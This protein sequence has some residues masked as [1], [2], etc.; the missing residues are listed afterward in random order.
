MLTSPKIL[1]TQSIV[2]LKYS[3]NSGLLR[4]AN[5]KKV[6]CSVNWTRYR[7]QIG[8]FEVSQFEEQSKITMTHSLDPNTL[9]SQYSDQ[10]FPIGILFDSTGETKTK[11]E[12]LLY[13]LSKVLAQPDQDI[14]LLKEILID[15]QEL[16]DR[17]SLVRQK[18]YIN[19]MDIKEIPVYADIYSVIS[20]SSI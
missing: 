6:L 1:N 16:L 4:Y 14:I 18:G 8:A 5:S 3:H 9:L 12:N 19:Y 2:F 15:L 7:S 20:K 11:F 13:Q 10:N 17:L